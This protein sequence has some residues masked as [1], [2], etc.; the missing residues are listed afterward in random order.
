MRDTA[1]PGLCVSQV[2]PGALGD[3]NFQ[4]GRR[5]GID[6]IALPVIPMKMGIDE[7]VDWV[8]RRF[9]KKNILNQDAEAG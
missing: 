7:R 9:L 3:N 5:L 2:L 8:L 6:L 1:D 4:I